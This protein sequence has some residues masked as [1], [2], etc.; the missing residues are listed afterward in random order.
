MKFIILRPRILIYLLINKC[1]IMAHKCNLVPCS[2]MFSQLNFFQQDM[3]TLHKRPWNQHQSLTQHS[4]TFLAQVAA[5]SFEATWAVNPMRR[6]VV[7]R[8]KRYPV[9]SIYS[10]TE[11]TRPESLILHRKKEKCQ[12]DWYRVDWALREM[13]VCC[14]VE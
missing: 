2:A 10:D 7:W 4:A 6:N 9:P 11:I 12:F 3:L 8:S 5:W 14:G 1:L 13:S